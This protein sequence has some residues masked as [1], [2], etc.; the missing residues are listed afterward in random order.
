MIRVFAVLLFSRVWVP[1]GNTG[2]VQI[3]AFQLHLSK[4]EISS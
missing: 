1:W 2:R 4:T 3:S